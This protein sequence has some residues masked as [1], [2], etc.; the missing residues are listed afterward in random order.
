MV[1][2][3]PSVQQHLPPPFPPF[4]LCKTL[5]KFLEQLSHLRAFKHTAFYLEHPFSWL[6]STKPSR[7]SSEDTSPQNLRARAPRRASPIHSH[8]PLC[9]T[10]LPH[11]SHY[12]VVIV[13]LQSS[14]TR[15]WNPLGKRLCL[16][17]SYIPSILSVMTTHLYFC[18]MLAI[19]VKAQRKTS[20][21][22]YLSIVHILSS[23]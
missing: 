8:S 9:L 4:P 2:L 15:L 16:V 12:T 23:F 13:S 11:L 21:G 7:L 1:Q 19:W 20:V 6:T 22:V 5:P 18:K 10:L 14:P 17:K 3:R